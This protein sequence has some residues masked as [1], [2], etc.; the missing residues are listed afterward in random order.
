MKPFADVVDWNREHDFSFGM[1][2]KSKVVSVSI[3]ECVDV[4][5]NATVT[6]VVYTVARCATEN[7]YDDIMTSLQSCVPTEKYTTQEHISTAISYAN[8]PHCCLHAECVLYYVDI[9]RC[10]QASS[11]W[12]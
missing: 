1:A 6:L 12:W 10:F 3:L 8:N 5:L 7:N 11:F 4:R 9:S 2:Q